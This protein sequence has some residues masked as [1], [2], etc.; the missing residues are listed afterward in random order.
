MD[1]GPFCHEFDVFIDRDRI[2]CCMTQTVQR[3]TGKFIACRRHETRIRQ[4]ILRPVRDRDVLHGSCAFESGIERNDHGRHNGLARDILRGRLRRRSCKRHRP[5]KRD[6]C[7]VVCRSLDAVIVSRPGKNHRCFLRLTRISTASD[8]EVVRAVTLD[9]Q[10][11]A[12]YDRNVAAFRRISAADV[13][14]V[15][16]AVRRNGAAADTDG[17]AC[18]VVAAADAGAVFT[19]RFMFEIIPIFTPGAGR[20]DRTA[21]DR[22]RSAG[23]AGPVSSSAADAGRSD[24]TGRR[25]RAARDRD[26]SA[27]SAVRVTAAADARA[28][29][30]AG[31]N[32]RAA[33]DRDRS[34]GTRSAA[35]ACAASAAGRR[36]DTV[37]DRDRSAGSAV[38]AADARAVRTALGRDRAAVDRDRSA[39]SDAV[40]ADARAAV[41]AGRIDG[42]AVDFDRRI[43]RRRAE[44]R[45]A[46]DAGTEP[47]LVLSRRAGAAALRR[48]RTAVHNEVEGS[49]AHVALNADAD[50]AGRGDGSVVRID[51]D[52]FRQVFAGHV[53]AVDHDGRAV[54]A[55]ARKAVRLTLGRDLSSVEGKN[56]FPETADAEAVADAG[57]LGA[58]RIQNAHCVSGR[59]GINGETVV[60]LNA[61][62]VHRRAVRQDQFHI[63][64]GNDGILHRH[65]SE[66]GIPAV[67]RY[68]ANECRIIPFDDVRRHDHV[69]R[70]RLYVAV[71]VEISQRR[72]VNE[73]LRRNFRHAVFIEIAFPAGRAFPIFIS[74]GGSTRRIR[75]MMRERMISARR[76]GDRRFLDHGFS[77]FIQIKHSAGTGP[78]FKAAVIAAV[79]RNG[80]M[81]SK[82]MCVCQDLMDELV[83][84]R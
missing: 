66:R 46:A 1:P 64:V 63:A 49:C 74:S 11:V 65:V 69:I 7:T 23:S 52:A 50:A 79:E 22:D 32:D 48:D 26:R 78:I 42:A 18:A 4:R 73:V 34:A 5:F 16:A 84:Q 13:G 12:A 61:G 75:R 82:L 58:D 62:D 44:I 30:A 57:R 27:G 56:D 38:T 14:R 2:A 8:A 19:G 21:R 10:G 54:S 47:V 41:S 36:H 60:N 77:V 35:D 59:L 29:I 37:V 55:D 33:V 3:P 15:R 39:G 31:R 51:P 17:S 76:D 45:P 25:D 70:D 24:F 81:V 68:A 72:T 9:R 6:L 83:I 67:R 20:R 28:V 71:F 53:A 43:D 80:R 40:S